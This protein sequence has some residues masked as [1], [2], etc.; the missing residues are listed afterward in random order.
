LKIVFLDDTT[1]KKY[2]K[3]EENDFL[4][5]SLYEKKIYNLLLIFSSSLII[6]VIL[7]LLCIQ[8]S[9]ETTST[10]WTTANLSQ[11]RSFLA[12]ISVNGVASFGADNFILVM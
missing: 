3:Y 2:K 10:T 5:V 12:A 8:E 4:P 6:S 1:D 7:S 11:H 9:S